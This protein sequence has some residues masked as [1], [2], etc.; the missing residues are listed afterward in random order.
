MQS[1]F[2]FLCPFTVL[3][4]ILLSGCGQKNPI[5]LGTAETI[6]LKGVTVVNETVKMSVPSAAARRFYAA[7]SSYK[8]SL[9]AVYGGFSVGYI[10]LSE[11]IEYPTP[12]TSGNDSWK[13]E[14]K[15]QIFVDRTLITKER[16]IY[17]AQESV[18][19]FKLFTVETACGCDDEK[20][21]TR[22]IKRLQIDDKIFQKLVD[23]IRVKDKSGNWVKPVIEKAPDEVKLGK[24]PPA[25]ILSFIGIS[26]S[27]SVDSGTNLDDRGKVDSESAH[28]G[29][30]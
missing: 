22:T 2:I 5:D 13:I 15:N 8:R 6:K 26:Q 29:K 3:A 12:S 14:G 7:E 23:Q 16:D 25:E 9:Y 17:F 24:S 28:G 20:R 21:I 4:I 30:L 27:M 11:F 19:R 10:P 18:I 1:R